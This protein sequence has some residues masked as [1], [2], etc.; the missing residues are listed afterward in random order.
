MR[1]THNQGFSKGVSMDQ[2][3]KIPISGTTIS[4]VN[5]R[6][7]F[8][9]DPKGQIPESGLTGDWTVERGF[10]LVYTHPKGYSFI[11]SVEILGGA[12]LFFGDG[13]NTE[14]GFFS[15]KT[16]LGEITSSYER[17]YTDQKDPN[18]DKL[19]IPL[20]AK[21]SPSLDL[22]KDGNTTKISFA[23]GFNEPRVIDIGL[24]R[25]AS[26]SPIDLSGDYPKVMSAHAMGL[27]MD[28][29]FPTL[30]FIARSDRP[31]GG[32]LSGNY[33]VC[34]RYYSKTGQ[35]SL[36]S[37]LGYRYFVSPHKIGN[38]HHDRVMGVSG[39]QTKEGLRFQAT[40][41][42]TRWDQ[43]QIISAYYETDGVATITAHQKV[44]I[45]SESMDFYLN[46]NNGDPL[47]VTIFDER[48][49][50]ISRAGVHSQ[51]EGRGYWG[52]VD[53]LPH[54]VVDPLSVS[55]K[56][57]YHDIAADNTLTP[58]YLPTDP[59]KS[60]PSNRPLTDSVIY[61][62]EIKL[63]KHSS[64]YELYPVS[65]DYP[66]YHG[67]QY[68]AMMAGYFRDETYPFMVSI[69]DRKGNVL[70]GKISINYRFPSLYSSKD[71]SLT[72]FDTSTNRWVLRAQ[73]VSISGIRIPAENLRGPDGKLNVS[74]FMVMRG[75]RAG[76]V[77]MQGVLVNTLRKILGPSEKDLEAV[78]NQTE[79]LTT[80]V[81][82]FGERSI[83][84]G[85][86][87][88][89]SERINRSERN[90]VRKT[91]NAD[92]DRIGFTINRASTFTF[93]SPDL[94]IEESFDREVDGDVLQMQGA[95]LPAYGKEVIRLSG[96][97][98]HFYTKNL[99]F[100]ADAVKSVEGRP[101]PGQNN[102]VQDALLVPIIEQP[103]EKYDTNQPSLTFVPDTTPF[104]STTG[105][106]GSGYRSVASQGFAHKNT[107]IVNTKDFSTSDIHLK[108]SPHRTALGLYNYLVP[109]RERD[110]NQP[111]Y[112]TGHYQVIDEEVLAQAVPIYEGGRLVAYEFNDVEIYGGDCY[113]NFFDFTRIYPNWG[114][115]EEVKRN[116]RDYSVSHIFPV[117]SKYN[118]D[119]RDG[120]RFARNAV[121]PA[122]YSCRG[123]LPYYSTGIMENQPENYAY[124]KSLLK[125]NPVQIH[126]AEKPDAEYVSQ[127]HGTIMHSDPRGYGDTDDGMRRIRPLAFL[128]LEGAHGRVT[129]LKNLFGNIY[130]W[131]QNAYGILRTNERATIPTDTSYALIGKGPV[132][133]G[134]S[135]ISTKYGLHSPHALLAD[136]RGAYW[137]DVARQTFIRHSQAGK[138]NLEDQDGVH[139]FVT[140]NLVDFSESDL[141]Y[142]GVIMGMDSKNRDV[143]FKTSSMH[144]FYSALISAFQMSDASWDPARYISMGSWMMSSPVASRHKVYLHGVGVAGMYYDKLY[145][146]SLALISNPSPEME[147][148]FNNCAIGVSRASSKRISQIVHRN[149]EAVTHIILPPSDNR[150]EFTDGALRYPIYQKGVD[151]RLFGSYMVVEITVRNRDYLIDQEDI[152]PTIHNF[153]TKFLYKRHAV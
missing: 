17:L 70:P 31:D 80:W 69:L 18:G 108:N 95:V 153:I 93:H 46:N 113:V 4:S 62:S 121:Q 51:S 78:F 35:Y 132:L 15:L 148:I 68:A 111:F 7:V 91:G 99:E 44:D 114:E 137:T 129:G 6:V 136:E 86:P 104:L 145:D 39:I 98:T 19:S 3:P 73:G 74:G 43:I 63:R 100:S 133:D 152:L 143:V 85:Y 110:E 56:P 24:M 52:D 60:G 50:S 135:Y 37:P 139:G 22:G 14:I 61:S 75:K 138:D 84:G 53:V 120:R 49:T 13:T 126:V 83:G 94:M 119:L 2:S 54:L 123:R 141:A 66:N 97:D 102:S 125:T 72:R 5:G 117:E 92:Q 36:P 57:I 47:P 33:E 90:R 105:D 146:S 142:D 144:M 8:N 20:S 81:N 149:K 101:M 34:I 11:D 124:N 109:T 65:A 29:F 55:A 130:C 41:I 38:T 42:D 27:R 103:I 12:V 112:S 26:G 23:D 127:R 147:K 1:E 122:L 115:C 59:T 116:F 134:V 64:A 151:Q 79:P 25:T 71:A 58:D 96:T 32:L 88:P 131:R 118:T 67:Q 87:Y 10:K 106:V 107:L 89:I 9:L 76:R 30:K 140:Q 40:G 45:T 82:K 77:A 28:L 128:D 150:A 16:K 48:F 21:I